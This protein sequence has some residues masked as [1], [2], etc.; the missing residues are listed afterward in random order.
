MMKTL[1]EEYAELSRS[2]SDKQKKLELTLDEIR[3]ITERRDA[4]REEMQATPTERRPSLQDQVTK[5]VDKLR[6]LHTEAIDQRHAIRLAQ[7]K[8]ECVRMRI[9]F[10][11]D[12]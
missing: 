9:E 6:H 5:C 2:A 1:V 4:L 3:S 11:L 12:A 7:I 8:V 10:D